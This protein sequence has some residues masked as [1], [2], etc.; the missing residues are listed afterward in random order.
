MAE[1]STA[2]VQALDDGGYLTVVSDAPTPAWARL[3]VA[4][5]QAGVALASDRAAAGRR[6]HRRATSTPKTS[7]PTA[8][9]DRRD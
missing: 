1:I 6:R 7:R 4:D 2:P 5:V 9:L 3:P 8:E